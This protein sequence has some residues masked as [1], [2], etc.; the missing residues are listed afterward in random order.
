MLQ[1]TSTNAQ[2]LE[3]IGYVEK[4]WFKSIKA[5]L[6]A[7][8][9]TGALTSSLNAP[10]YEVFKKNGEEWVRFKIQKKSGKRIVIKRPVERFVRI[11]RAGVDVKRRPIIK[12]KVCLAGKSQTAEFSLTDR[13]A[14]NY[15]AIVGRTFMENLFVVNPAESFLASKKCKS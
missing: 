1:F 6:S 4:L 10:D 9:D 15:Q 5:S 3:E 12:L 14:M 7:K 2:S 8:I 13:S 11:R